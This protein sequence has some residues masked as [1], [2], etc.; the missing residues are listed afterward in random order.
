MCTK[1][2]RGRLNKGPGLANE[3]TRESRN[4]EMREALH[5]PSQSHWSTDFKRT[6]VQ[7]VKHAH[8]INK[9]KK[10]TQNLP[11]SF[12]KYCEI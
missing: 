4:M 7:K 9:Q 12:K 8:H 11:E 5:I 10:H 3:I 2:A 1:S 6:S